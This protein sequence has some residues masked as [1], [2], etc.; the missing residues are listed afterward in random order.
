MGSTEEIDDAVTATANQMLISG[1]ATGITLAG[2]PAAGEVVILEISRNANHANDDLNADAALL[3]ID[4]RV[5]V[6][7]KAD[8]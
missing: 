6:N 3:A 1:W 2:T 4:V 5:G 8:G 7:K